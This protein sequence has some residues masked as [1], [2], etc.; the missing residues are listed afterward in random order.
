MVMIIVMAMMNVYGYD[1][2]WWQWWSFVAMMIVVLLA[3]IIRLVS[4][5]DCHIPCSFFFTI[6]IFEFFFVG[7]CRETSY[8]LYFIYSDLVFSWCFFSLSTRGF[9]AVLSVLFCLVSLFFLWSFFCPLVFFS[10]LAS[11]V[12]PVFA[13]YFFK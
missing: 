2:R 13:V 11:L 4:Y 3:M 9:F 8:F 7:F 12:L 1:D 10:M 6:L 5:D